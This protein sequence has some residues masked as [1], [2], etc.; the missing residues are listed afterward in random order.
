[1]VFHV[2]CRASQP[3]KES[4]C[5]DEMVQAENAVEAFKKALQLLWQ[6]LSTD[7]V[8]DTLSVKVISDEVRKQ[9][10]EKVKQMK[11][12]IGKVSTQQVS[13]VNYEVSQYMSP[14]EGQIY[15]SNL[16]I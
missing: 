4:W 12:Q 13:K 6:C 10:L 1:M 7:V 2:L 11:V 9:E 8:L 15:E 5:V 3:G 16:K 14:K